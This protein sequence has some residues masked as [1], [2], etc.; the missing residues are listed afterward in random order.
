[1]KTLREQIGYW[2]K[3]SRTSRRI[4]DTVLE[5]YPAPPKGKPMIFAHVDMDPTRKTSLHSI[6][7]A[8]LYPTPMLPT[9]FGKIYGAK[10]TPLEAWGWGMIPDGA[11]PPGSPFVLID[12][13]N[14]VTIY[15]TGESAARE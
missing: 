4:I 1:V 13:E 7:G 14:Q 8:L 10:G 9:P 3:A 11:P 12:R 5:K 2:D 15:E 6:R